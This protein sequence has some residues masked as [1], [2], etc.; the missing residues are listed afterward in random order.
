MDM[1]TAVKISAFVSGS[2]LAYSVIE[3][4]YRGDGT[5]SKKSLMD[6]E[7]P[8]M[9]KVMGPFVGKLNALNKKIDSASFASY[10][11]NTQKKLI[12]AGRPFMMTPMDFVSLQQIS[13]FLFLVLG[14]FAA[15]TIGK[16]SFLT[17]LI[18]AL[19]GWF[20]PAI[21]LSE[22]ISARQKAILRALPYNTDLVTLCVEAGLD[23]MRA[24]TV[25]IQQGEQG[26]LASELS[27][28]L[29][30]TK[31]GKTKKEALEDMAGRIDLQ[32]VTLFVSAVV[33]AE[34]LGTPL[35]EALRIQS[36]Q[37]RTE[38]FQRAEKTAQEAPVKL[39]LPLL[40]FIFPAVFIILFGPIVLKWIYEGGM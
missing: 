28:A 5:S 21:W 16:L 4:F 6:R 20:L 10:L 36:E 18:L 13:L 38:R 29:Q 2:C 8:A 25:V 39:L 9:L 30:E 37:R 35:G 32:A 22:T 15:S 24:V 40:V 27:Q 11:R 12:L 14:G 23:F 19:I 17:L 1:G 7:A 34:K 26:P 33:Q 3:I 31:M